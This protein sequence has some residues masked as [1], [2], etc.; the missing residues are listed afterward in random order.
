[1]QEF[2][3]IWKNCDMGVVQRCHWLVSLSGL[4]IWV[5]LINVIWLL[6]L[7]IQFAT[8]CRLLTERKITRLLSYRTETCY[9]W[10]DWPYDSYPFL[11]SMGHNWWAALLGQR[12]YVGIEFGR[13][14]A[15][16]KG[17]NRQVLEAMPQ[18]F[19]LRGMCYR[20]SL[21][22]LM[23]GGMYESVSYANYGIQALLFLVAYKNMYPQTQLPRI[24]QLNKL[25]DF[26]FN[27]CYPSSSIL[28]CMNFWR[29]WFFWGTFPAKPCPQLLPLH[30]L[31]PSTLLYLLPAAA[32]TCSSKILFKSPSLPTKHLH[33]FA[34]PTTSA[35]P[36][37]INFC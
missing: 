11:D 32:I 23:T 20:I 5:R 30:T 24:P 14:L 18:W 37:N 29:W 21:N 19:A 13:G 8:I 1:M 4:L 12:R 3:A 36:A 7:I 25:A 27:V 6:W 2:V 26:Y 34:L 16:G 22:L 31:P 9:R 28:R 35:A 10:L 15:W 17:S 33:P